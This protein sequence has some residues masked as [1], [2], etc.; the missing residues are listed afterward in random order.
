MNEIITKNPDEYLNMLAED[1]PGYKT[2][3]LFDKYGEPTPATLRAFNETEKGILEP[4]TI[5]EMRAEF[6]AFCSED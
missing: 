5:E 4:V 2:E 3:Q 6:N 1:L